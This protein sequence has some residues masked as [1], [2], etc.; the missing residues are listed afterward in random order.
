MPYQQTLPAETRDREVQELKT[1]VREQQEMLRQ[2]APVQK[3]AR[4]NGAHI[5]T[6]VVLGVAM[7]FSFIWAVI[8]KVSESAE[9]SADRA[10]ELALKMTETSP[11]LNYM[12]GVDL[13]TYMALLF[14][15]AGVIIWIVCKSG[16]TP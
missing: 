2:H 4:L 6:L 9:R 16:V 14:L 13:L 7:L 3:P 1:M 10:H 5:V 12:A 15:G 8:N 11:A